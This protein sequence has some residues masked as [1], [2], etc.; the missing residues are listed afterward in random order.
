MQPDT[1]LTF[2]NNTFA[3]LFN[4]PD[5]FLQTGGKLV[6]FLPRPE[7]QVLKNIIQ[8]FTPQEPDHE[9]QREMK[10][11]DDRV[12]HFLTRYRAFFQEDGTLTAIQGVWSDITLLTQQEER[13]RILSRA[14]EESPAI[15][16][17]TNA[18]GKI[19]YINNRFS[20]VTGYSRQEVIGKTPSLLK[21]GEVDQ[22]VYENLWE[23][24]LHGEI[25]RGELHN[26]RRDGTLYW[27]NV[28]IAPITA[29]NGT[30]TH[31][32]GVQEEITNQKQ[33]AAELLQA[34]EMAEEANRVKGEFLA[35]MSHEIRTPMNA[36]IGMTTLCMQTETTAKQRD[37][38]EKIASSSRSLLGIIN[39]ILD[40]SKLESNYLQVE[41]IPFS[42][43]EVLD[44]LYSLITVNSNE[45]KLNFSIVGNQLVPELLRGDPLRLEQVLV[46]LCSNAV[47]FTEQGKVE[48]QIVAL[49][50]GENWV[51]LGFSVK[52]TGIGMNEVER[53]RLFRPFSQ[54]DVSTTRKYGGS[55]LGL[56]IC[57]RLVGLMG[58]SIQ[59][60]STPGVGTTFF[61]DVPFAMVEE[62]QALVGQT[63]RPAL[64]TDWLSVLKG[65]RALLVEDNLLNQQ[66]AIE[67]LE[68]AGMDVHCALQGE[69]AI[70]MVAVAPYDIVLM[71]VQMPVL[72][73]L[74]A[75]RRIRALDGFMA[76]PIIAMTANA[77]DSDRER[78]LSA[79]M[80]DHI[81][82][83][84]EPVRLYTV[85]CKWLGAGEEMAITP[86]PQEKRAKEHASVEHIPG[87]DW[88]SALDL[89]DDNE[90]LLIKLL[91][92]FVELHDK[93]GQIIRQ[94][95]LTGDRD[96]AKRLSHSM[97]S[98]AGNM[99]AKELQKAA[100]ALE[101]ALL[102]SE[103]N[104]DS[105]VDEFS[106]S[107]DRICQSIANWQ[108]RSH[109]DDSMA[110]SPM[111]ESDADWRP[112]Y[113]TLLDQLQHADLDAL[114]SSA[115]LVPLLRGRVE[116]QKLN[117]VIQWIE[118]F[119][120]EQAERSLKSLM[121]KSQLIAEEEA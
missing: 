39:N 63:P 91:N 85:L 45:K 113:L 74:E 5:N 117:Q 14:T 77:L 42:L 38:L 76:L 11:Q 31:F 60:E 108:N 53:T 93:D 24:I 10:L 96:K 37:Y 32:V 103:I 118:N 17:I 88:Q 28:A 9:S 86:Q 21:S 112:L 13:I 12:W 98:V 87:I 66:V 20:K 58:G 107:L 110:L 70:I 90:E 92:K 121:H 56:A 43:S 109:P 65:K 26:R 19:E 89:L 23:T 3:R 100:T 35:N 102:Q 49:E 8:Q 106:E 79:G 95:L 94:A 71:D 4:L 120:Y 61:F 57:H 29:Q 40:F 111:N 99:G 64:E 52:D 78:C 69:E 101:K 25:W 75:T 30:I 55:G 97:K 33:L 68:K 119:D 7:W 84:V 1:T 6:G 62:G 2:Y 22:P 115:S 81:I 18:D 104:C 67:F 44:N 105:L 51:H 34:K 73:G 16:V 36:I 114:E 50:K 80:N 48:L 54:G 83:P 116:E 41:S 15:V 46:N 72:D 27:V 59:V 47:K 82:K